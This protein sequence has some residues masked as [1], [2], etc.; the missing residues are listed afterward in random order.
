[1]HM[2]KNNK[3]NIRK[4]DVQAAFR[5]YA[6]DQL[7]VIAFDIEFWLQ[8]N[9]IAPTLGQ[10]KKVFEAMTQSACVQ[11]EARYIAEGLEK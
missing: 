3:A 10:Y 6:A 1:M 11:D 2:S 4:E 8:H 7:Q 5:A 9:R